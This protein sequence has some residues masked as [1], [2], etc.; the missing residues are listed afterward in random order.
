MIRRDEIVAYLDERLGVASIEDVSCNGLQVEGAEEIER[1]GIATDAALATYRRAIELDCQL[2]F[3][4]HGLIWGGLRGVTGRERRHL[5]L[6]LKNELNLYAAHLPLD[7]HPELGNNAQLAGIVDLERR[8]PFGDYHGNALGLSGELPEPLTLLDLAG[9]F[10]SKIGGT[11]KTLPFG[12]EQVRTLAIVSGAGS[13]DLS[14]AAEQGLDAFVTG[15]GRH[16]D[17]HLAL[18]SGVNVVYLGHYHSETVGVRAVGREL[19][20]RF[21]VESTFIDVPTEF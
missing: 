17:H 21:G 6:L 10:Q 18:E 15:E 7:A 20:K 1:V 19:E 4:H 3:V 12:P 13:G 14:L 2:L 5:E 9:R 8:R 11:P 16:E